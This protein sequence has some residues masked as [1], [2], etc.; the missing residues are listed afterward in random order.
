MLFRI[1]HIGHP[2]IGRRAREFLNLIDER[3]IRRLFG[4]EARFVFDP[5]DDSNRPL[6]E[7]HGPVVGHWALYPKFLTDL[8]TRAFT[9]GLYDPS[10]RV[11]ETEWRRAMSR[12]RDS[13]TSCPECGAK[14]FY[15]AQRL[16]AKRASFPCWS[17]GG[18]VPSSPPRIGIRRAGARASEAP[19]HVVILEPGTQLFPHH[20]AGAEYDF[21]RPTAEVIAGPA[22]RNLSGRDWTI[23]QDGVATRLGH[24]DTV[25]LASGLRVQFERADGEVKM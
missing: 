5:A 19:A 10:A 12:L 4:T 23:T 8:F 22:L 9:E 18:E 7:E 17:C 2:L 21:S 24:A 20:S 6:A 14:S 16:A 13:V 25:P 15:D 1:L 3:A 11:V